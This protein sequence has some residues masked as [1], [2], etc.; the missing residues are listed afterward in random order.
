MDIDAMSPDE[1][2][3]KVRELLKQ[4]EEADAT[5]A[6]LRQQLD[7]GAGGGAA[8][9]LASPATTPK[10]SEAQMAEEMEKQKQAMIDAMLADGTISQ[11]EYED[12]MERNRREKEVQQLKAYEKEQ[13]DIQHLQKFIRECGTYSN[14]V[15][16]AQSKQ[17]IIDKMVEA[18]LTLKPVDDPKCARTPSA[19]DASAGGIH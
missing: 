14:L 12:M 7:G 15:K 17:K 8:P 13:D 6:S 4:K 19:A 1:L 5:I 3:Q 16:Q 2:K 10:K 11:E 9:E 18:G